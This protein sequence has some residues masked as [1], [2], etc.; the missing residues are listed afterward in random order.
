MN[1]LPAL[2]L[3]FANHPS[4]S[5]SGVG[6]YGLTEP[7]EL[8]N[9]HDLAPDVYRGM[10]GAPGHQAAGLAPD[11]S[12]RRDADGN[13]MG[14]RGSYSNP[15]AGTF[16]G[17]D[18]MTA[19]VGGVWD[20]LLGEGRRFWIVAT[21][22]SHANFSETSQSAG[23]FWPGQFQKTYVYAGR[24][25]ADVLDGLRRGRVFTVAGDLITALDVTVEAAGQRAD[26]GGTLRVLAGT[27]AKTLIRFVHATAPNARG[28]RPSVARVDL[29]AGEV[30]GPATSRNAD[31]NETTKVVR[32]LSSSDWTTRDGVTTMEIALGPVARSM[33][34]RVRGTNTADLEPPM[35]AVGEDPWTDLWFYSNP[36]FIDVDPT[37]PPRRSS[38]TVTDAS[39]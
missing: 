30:Q 32:R 36:V 31:R 5:A 28:D 37:V 8:R 23:D 16:G 21:S 29:V 12:I 10:E 24:T 27:A 7:R 33:Y 14:A 25:Y 39:R 22:D 11:G 3:M 9:N 4:R 1:A 2:P 38:S 34:V 35:D 18:Q 17:Y 13:P 6:L 19:R 15:S 26:I 20:A